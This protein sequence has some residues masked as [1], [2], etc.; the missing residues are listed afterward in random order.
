MT[1]SRGAVDDEGSLPAKPPTSDSVLRIPRPNNPFF[2]LFVLIFNYFI[3][4]VFSAKKKR[5]HFYFL[6]LCIHFLANC[7]V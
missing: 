7:N 6:L 2:L 1:E 5:S 4:F 3:S